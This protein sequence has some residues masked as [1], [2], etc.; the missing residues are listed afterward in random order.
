MSGAGGSG[1]GP[2]LAVAGNQTTCAD[3]LRALC[4]AGHRPAYLLHM[5][6]EHAAGI[7]DYTDLAPLAEELG[8]EVIRPATYAFSSQADRDLFSGLRIDLLVSA[9]WQRIFPEWF[10][11][12]LSIGAFG[13]HGSADDLPRGRGRSPM[14]WAIIEGR[15]TFHTSLFRY[16]AGVDSG[17]VVGTLRFD[18]TPRDDIRSL[19]HKN[20]L[21]QI[22]LLLRHLPA[23]LDGTAQL[24][25]QRADVAPT[26]YPKREPRDG[27]IDWRDSLERVDRLVRAVG[28]P[29]PGAFSLCGGSRVNIWAGRPFDSRLDFPGFEPGEIAAVFEDETFVAV[30]AGGA[31]YLVTDWDAPDGWRPAEGRVFE[32]RENPGWEKLAAMH[33]GE[34]QEGLAFTRPMYARLLD[35]LL[36]GGYRFAPLDEPDDGAEPVVF[37]RHDVDKSV[38]RALEMARMEHERGVRATYFLLTRGAFYNLLEPETAAMVRGIA[39]LGHGVGLHFDQRMVPG[40]DGDLDRAVERELNL[41]DSLLPVGARRAVTFHNPRPEVVRRQ[42]GGAYVS[43]YQPDRMPP[44][45][46][47]LSESNAVWREGDPAEDLRRAR[48]PRL[49]LLVHPLWW[50]NGHRMRPQDVLREVVAERLGRV[51]AYLRESN[52]L[53]E[54]ARSKGEPLLPKRFADG[55]G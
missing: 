41:L 45:C 9:G 3:V 49:Q 26:Y 32:S 36:E 15:D 50:M 48:W 1:G 22:R 29:Y 20:T 10:L 47:Y 39:E 44:A 53:W 51:D 55:E 30:C 8:V 7:A 34:G 13:M 25:P 54:A 24:T 11:R 12:G 17:E 21:S 33:A 6:P 5:G 31:G 43:G 4:A 35:A 40:A 38:A 16:D 18:I 52:H 23:L 46:K 2:V 42:P 28:R 14:N 37:L 19:R 27:V